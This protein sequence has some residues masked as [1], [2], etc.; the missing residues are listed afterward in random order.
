[1]QEFG[2]D[3]G[4]ECLIITGFIASPLNYSENLQIKHVPVN[5]GA[6]PSGRWMEIQIYRHMSLTNGGVLASVA[7]S[8]L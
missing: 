5:P 3:S 6:L 1:M 7:R 2:R 8:L 4:C